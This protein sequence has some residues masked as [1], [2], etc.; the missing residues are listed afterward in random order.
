MIDLNSKLV[1]SFGRVAKKLRISVTDR[2]NMRCIYC[3]PT[4]NTDWFEQESILTFDEIIRVVTILADLGVDRIRLTG[5]EPLVRPNI[6]ILIK[7]LSKVAGIKAISMTTNGLGLQSAAS[8]LTNAGL[9][10]VNVSLDT[11]R[12]NR[13]KAINGVYGLENVLRGIQAAEDVGLHVKI[14]TVMIRGWND[15]EVVEFAEFARRTNYTVRFIEFMPLDG[16][17]L[18]GS[19]LVVSKAEIIQKLASEGIEIVPLFN[20]NSEPARLFT[21][22]DKR[23]TIG[24]IP[25]ITEPFCVNCDRIRLTSDGKLLTCLYEKPG[26]DLKEVLRDGKSNKEIEGHILESI[27]NK[28]EGIIGL[29]RGKSLRPTMNLMYK[30]GG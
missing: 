22:V 2:C 4:N 11:L 9:G 16:T 6:S 28:P 14:N 17:S 13:F 23:G 20:D 15:D 30:I 5:G 25:S 29:I 19:H 21:F 3:M 18:W 27:K 24:F 1:D 7:G 10:S 8:D 12:N 26:K